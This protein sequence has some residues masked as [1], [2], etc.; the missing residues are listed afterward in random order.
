MNINTVNNK[1]FKYYFSWSFFFHLSVVALFFLFGKLVHDK[2]QKT[3]DYNLKLISASVKVA[4][5]PVAF[6][7]TFIC[8]PIVIL[9]KSKEANDKNDLYFENGIFKLSL[10]ISYRSR[11]V[12][13]VAVLENLKHSRFDAPTHHVLHITND[14]LDL[15]HETLLIDTVEQLVLVDVAEWFVE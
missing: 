7:L 15:C 9:I 12:N 14:K 5:A 8:I 2:I 4:P 6:F 10:V 11:L 13:E 1:T 3:K